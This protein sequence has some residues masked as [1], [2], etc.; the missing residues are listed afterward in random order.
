VPERPD[1]DRLAGE[2]EELFSELWQVPRFAGLRHGFRPQVDCFRTD[3]PAQLTVVV[4]LP[5][6]DA[7]D[8]EIAASPGSLVVSGQRRRPRVPGR[9]YQQMELDYGPFQRQIAL[10]DDVDTAGAHASYERGLLT[11]VLPVASRPTR[12]TKVSIEVSV[13]R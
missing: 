10:T 13:Q 8:I 4:E 1:I 5:G 11:V 12:A 3:D 2:I 7:E 9:H 6:V